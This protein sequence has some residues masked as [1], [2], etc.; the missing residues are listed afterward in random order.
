MKDINVIEKETK[1]KCLL[2]DVSTPGDHN[3]MGKEIVQL[4]KYIELWI[5]VVQ[6]TI[7]TAI[8]VALGVGV[9]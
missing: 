9:Y 6:E 8:I 1:K 3:I 7:I 4:K 2:I 5:G